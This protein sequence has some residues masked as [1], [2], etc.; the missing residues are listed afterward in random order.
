[1]A[2]SALPS[3]SPLVLVSS[4]VGAFHLACRLFTISVPWV[5]WQR[6]QVTGPSY[7]VM[8]LCAAMGLRT[9]AVTVKAPDLVNFVFRSR[10]SQL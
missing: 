6:R 2:P 8:V 9:G 3:S 1:M 7:R 4:G 5:A 10:S